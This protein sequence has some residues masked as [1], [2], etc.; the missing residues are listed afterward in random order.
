MLT[1]TLF[2]ILLLASF[3]SVFAQNVGIGTSTPSAKLHIA[4]NVKIA[5]GTQGAGKVLT[6]DANGLA[7]WATPAPPT[8]TAVF[9]PTTVIGT[10]QWMSKNLD[11]AFYKNGDPI[12]QVTD[13]TAWAALTTGAW[14]YYNNDSTQGTTYGKLYNWYAVNDSRGLAPTGWHIPSEAEWTALSATLGGNSVSGAKMKEAGTLHWGLPK[15]NNNSS[16][17][18]L[19]GGYRNDIGS[20]SLIGDLGG[21][22]SST[23]SG[24]T[25]ARGGDLYFN[26]SAFNTNFY[27]KLYGFSVRCVRD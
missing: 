14:C 15:G 4:G 18:G 17:T 1:R 13:P 3:Q 20:F 5:D 25:S 12:P 10:Q 7:S 2:F 9:L 8:Q 11:A 26:T 21:W 24:T 22:W 6:S 19:P 16:F 23:A 27:P